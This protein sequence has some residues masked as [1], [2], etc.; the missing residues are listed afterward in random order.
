MGRPHEFQLQSWP[1]DD[2]VRRPPRTQECLGAGHWSERGR[3][4][5]DGVD[6][7]VSQ[8]LCLSLH[9]TDGAAETGNGDFGTGS[10]AE[11][12]L[13]SPPHEAQA[14]GEAA[15]EDSAALGEE[16]GREPF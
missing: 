3:C 7:V 8:R 5:Q 14:R 13:V 10:P 16:A 15:S 9:C 4:L 12:H 6:A 2:G 11:G 1:Q